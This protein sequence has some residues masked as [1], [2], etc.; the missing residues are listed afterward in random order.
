MVQSAV[1]DYKQNIQ[2]FYSLV[3]FSEKHQVPAHRL[4]LQIQINEK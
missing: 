3:C 1:N 4:S 2:L